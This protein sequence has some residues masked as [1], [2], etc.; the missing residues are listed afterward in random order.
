MKNTVRELLQDKI[1]EVSIVEPDKSAHD[2]MQL[3]A[4]KKIGALPVLEAGKLVGIISERDYPGKAKVLDKPMQDVQVKEIMSSN[5]VH[6][7]PD[8]TIEHCMGLVAE[9]RVRHLP[10]LKN[11]R[12]IGI[13]S[14]GDLSKM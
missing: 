14:I 4:D 3:M 7:S 6:V 1:H 5:V 11:D 12:V 13:I 2:A 9:K 10:V 8:D